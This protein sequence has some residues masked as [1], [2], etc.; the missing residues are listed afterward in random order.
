MVNCKI[1]SR[2]LAGV[3]FASLWPAIVL[4]QQSPWEKY[5]SDGHSAYAQERYV[6]AERLYLDALKEA[7]K[8]GD[9]DTRLSISLNNLAEF[10]F[11]QDKLSK[12]EPLYRRAVT[13]AEKT[14]GPEHPSTA[15]SLNNLAYLYRD[16]GKYAEA[17]PLLKRS[18]AI[19]EKVAA[20]VWLVRRQV[21]TG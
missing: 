15:V 20:A 5:T 14:L 7:E 10:Y 6:E 18:L 19:W 9:A 12:V 13:I 2:V 4:A 21:L 11:D 3:L 1:I 17:E 8:F 16:Q